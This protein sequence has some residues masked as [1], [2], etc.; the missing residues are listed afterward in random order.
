MITVVD[1][2]L[3]ACSQLKEYA[4]RGSLLSDY[5]LL[6]FIRDTYDGTKLSTKRT[7]EGTGSSR[8]S[9]RSDYRSDDGRASKCRV[10][11]RQG[12][13]T[14]VE[15][16]GSWFPRSDNVE[17][18]SMYCATMLALLVPWQHLASIH[19]SSSS[20]EDEF[21]S[22]EARATVDQLKFIHNIQ[23]FHESSDSAQRKRA[24]DNKS[25]HHRLINVEDIIDERSEDEE[26]KVDIEVPQVT[27][28][29]IE[30]AICGRFCATDQLFATTAMAIAEDVGIF[31]CEEVNSLTNAIHSKFG[32]YATTDDVQQFR[33][34]EDNVNA[35]GHHDTQESLPDT[36]A[37][38]DPCRLT[39]AM[40]ID[41]EVAVNHVNY[42]DDLPHLKALNVEQHM[43]HDIIINHLDAYLDD[44]NPRQI[45]MMVIGQ[46]GTGKSTLLNAITTSF[47]HRDVP[48]LLAKTAMSGVAASLIGG[49]TLHLWAGLPV[50][51]LPQGDE[52]MAK[53]RKDIRMRR[54]KNVGVPIWLA[55][56][57]MGMLTKD[58][59]TYL[60][61][62]AGAVRTGDGH[63]DSTIAFGA[64][65]ILLIGDFHQFPPVGHNNASLY[66]SQ[67][68]RISCTIGENLF[69]QFDTVIELTEQRRITD[70]V[71]RD[72]LHN[73]RTGDCNAENLAEIRKLVLTNPACDIPNFMV[74]PWNDAVLVTP[75]NCVRVMWNEAK[76][77]EHCARTGQ[78]RYV[79]D[80][81][82]TAGRDRRPL[83]AKERLHVAK[84][85]IGATQKIENRIT[86]AIGMKAMVTKNIATDLGLANGSRGTIVDI[87]L[88][89]RETTGP[90]DII[91]GAVH[92]E[93]PPAMILFEPSG[94]PEFET[95]PGLKPGQVPIFPTE[96]KFNI[97]DKKNRTII[98]RRQITL[99]P[100]YAFTDHKGQGQTLGN[101]VVDI[102][103]LKTFP[104][105]QFAAY[106]ALSR[107]WGRDSIRLLRDFDD[108]LFTVHPS[109]DLK[110]E[111]ERLQ[112]LVKQTKENWNMGLYHLY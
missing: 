78:V 50:Q 77:K 58:L 84:L 67:N 79:I 90:K 7:K 81:E 101:V 102:G 103:K 24:E 30:E 61:Q 65:N 9:I 3:Q 20:I 32:R 52:W 41:P 100:A 111:D 31:M 104:V 12:H 106:V 16:V 45:L 59:T 72:I 86:V 46:G 14:M 38:I 97:G 18:R 110:E 48:H 40:D 73:A 107:S 93:F 98:A 51:R 22:F 4:E 33:E 70:P 92:L 43:A 57:E 62:V 112:V 109:E 28:E 26:M 21:I 25:D 53:S 19:G 94:G 55:I 85:D 108:R 71:W 39:A 34:W 75:R 1:G 83:S 36:S 8:A 64:L 15:F 74:T 96:V 66:S 95:F 44:R 99:T 29:Q 10:L 35:I 49:S 6:D 60:S 2:Q 80:A 91:D 47:I 42:I 76:L 11:R 27:E 17:S 82:D 105:N 37:D 54:E 13:Q 5:C 69:N 89:G 87:V 23:Y 68:P 56:D 63:A 88:D